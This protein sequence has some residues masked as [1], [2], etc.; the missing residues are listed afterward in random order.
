[1]AAHDE[2]PTLERLA[3]LLADSNA[4][5]RLYMGETGFAALARRCLAANVRKPEEIRLLS[6]NLPDF[7]ASTNPFSRCPE[8]SELARLENAFQAARNAPE[9]ASVRKLQDPWHPGLY[10]I[11]LHPSVRRVR[12]RTNA[13]SIWSALAAAEFPPAPQCLAE[14]QELL[15]WHQGTSSRFRMLGREE[16]AAID[17]IADGGNF[18]IA[19][20]TDGFLR[21]WLE[22]G[23]ISS[24]RNLNDPG[25]K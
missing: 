11:A 7:L 3:G 15:V 8:L 1:M 4:R 9:A 23:I 16:A 2:P 19:Q 20:S 5:L 24:L 12:L 21:G 25:E 10:R 6:R 17:G 14:P 18:E 13:A 22:A